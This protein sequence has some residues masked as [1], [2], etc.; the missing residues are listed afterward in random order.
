MLIM[1]RGQSLAARCKPVRE[2]RWVPI[3]PASVPGFQ[4]DRNPRG[5]RNPE[6][7]SVIK[8]LA[9]QMLLYHNGEVQLVA[10]LVNLNLIERKRLPTSAAAWR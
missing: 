6:S 9:D 2:A 3:C 8:D 1:N 7:A 5:R 10:R 4:R